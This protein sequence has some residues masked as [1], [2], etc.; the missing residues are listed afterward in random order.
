M[1]RRGLHALGLRHRLHDRSLP[2][3]PDLVYRRVRVAVFV[4][5]CFWHGHHCSLGV[6]P[7]SNAIFWAQKIARNQARDQDALVR[8]EQMGWRSV[9][10][11]ECAIRGPGRRLTEAVLAEVAEFIRV[12][13]P[14]RLEV[15]EVRPG[16]RS[17]G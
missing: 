12:G 10:V 1:I 16:S 5:G 6:A 8:L 15:T 9:L 17:P 11:W 7:R 2:G 14:T 13:G 3:T 4:H